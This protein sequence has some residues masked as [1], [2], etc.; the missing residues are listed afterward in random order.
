MP[1]YWLVP[2]FIVTLKNPAAHRSELGGVIAGLDSYLLDG[3]HAGLS[4]VRKA[5]QAA[6]IAGC[7]SLH[8]DLLGVIRRPVNDQ[9]VARCV[10]RAWNELGQGKR[11]PKS[12]ARGIQSAAVHSQKL[13]DCRVA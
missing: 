8:S 6:Q 13:E 4:L 2:D 1:W 9:S 12:G 11:I 10:L 3:V 5:H 7:L